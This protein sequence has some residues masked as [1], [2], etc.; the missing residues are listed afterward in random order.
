MGYDYTA[1]SSHT[2]IPQETPTIECSMCS[3]EID[4]FYVGWTM[5]EYQNDKRVC[6]EWDCWREFASMYESDI[7]F[8]DYIEDYVDV[9]SISENDWNEAVNEWM[10]N[11]Y[12]IKKSD[13]W[14]DI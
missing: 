2:E 5:S 11:E 13:K 1:I 7:P 4:T 8:E 9:D 12:E 3:E 14:R 10:F 6:G